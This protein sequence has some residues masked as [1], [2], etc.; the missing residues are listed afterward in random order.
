VAV[1]SQEPP[2]AREIQPGIPEK[3]SAALAK[4]LDKDPERRQPSMRDFR[5]ELGY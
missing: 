3:V 4:A 5:K 2:L 1:Q